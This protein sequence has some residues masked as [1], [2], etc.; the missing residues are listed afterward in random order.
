[1]IDSG[2]ISLL[3]TKLY[4]PPVADD[5]VCRGA[6]HQRLESGLSMPLSLVSAPAGYGKSTLVSHWLQTSSRPSAWL[7]LEESDG[8]VSLFLHYVITAIRTID[9]NAC[10]SVL[11]MLAA[12]EPPPPQVLGACLADDLSEMQDPFILVLDDYHRIGSNSVNELLTGLLEHPASVLHLVLITRRNPA[13]PIASLRAQGRMTEVRLRD[14]EFTQAETKSLMESA[15]DRQLAED[16]LA[17]VHASTEGWPVGLRLAMLAMRYHADP[18]EFLRGFTGDVRQL[19]DYLIAEVMEHETPQIRNALCKIAILDRFCAPLCAAVCEA[20]TTQTA[21]KT[22]EDV[23]VAMLERSGLL[24]VALDGNQHWFRFHHLFQALLQRELA[25]RVPADEIAVMRARAAEWLEGEG[26]LEE[27]MHHLEK[28]KDDE[29]MRLMI[30]RNRRTLYHKEKWLRLEAL[31]S[32]LPKGVVQ[33]DP[34]LLMVKC[35]TGIIRQRYPEIWQVVQRTEELLQNLEC[36]EQLAPVWGQLDTFLSWRSYAEADGETALAYAKSAIQRL[37]AHFDLERGF[38]QMMCSCSLQ[39][40]GKEAEGIQYIYDALDSD[41]QA[42]PIYRVRLLEALGFL[43]WMGGDL[44]RLREAGAAMIRLGEKESLPVTIKDGHYIKGKALY[45]LGELQEAKKLFTNVIKPGYQSTDRYLIRSTYF[46]AKTYNA[47]GEPDR[48]VLL[49]DKMAADL[50]DE[51]NSNALSMVRAFQAELA[52]RRGRLADATNW[53]ETFEP[54]ATPRGDACW[55]D[56]LIATNILLAQRTPASLKEASRQLASLKSYFEKIHN[57][58][59]LI[60]TLALQALVFE[61]QDSTTKAEASMKEAI[62][63]ALP[64]G[65]IQL[66]VDMGPNLS[67]LLNR[68]T[69]DEESLRYVGRIQAAFRGTTSASQKLIKPA[70]TGVAIAQGA[71]DQLDPLTKREQE[72]LLLLTDKLSN[73]EIATRLYISTGTVKRH[74]NSLYSKLGVHNRRDA[75]AKAT[76]LG[77]LS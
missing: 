70:A 31:M 15:A 25:A 18:D 69:L 49:L 36:T 57:T 61:A 42:H 32:R 12:T 46:L 44:A 34:N 30:L 6:L 14:L 68:L 72:I 43:L 73:L 2:S 17:H 39:M 60:E 13:L 63:R 62:A 33:N 48:A 24:C 52:L 50:L 55:N 53:L 56:E 21:G 41:R 4:P 40:V 65:V 51:A 3:R 59:F 47:M 26:Y 75:V 35:W 1:M 23:F 11:A 16:A 74:T 67:Y 64:C 58:R 10:P 8:D 45:S 28:I 29:A 5:V 66:F 76:G 7:S 54:S 20:D 77:I 71:T 22:S 27:A 19:Q 9:P 37:P 38:A